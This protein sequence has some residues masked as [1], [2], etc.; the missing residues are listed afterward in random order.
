MSIQLREQVPLL[1]GPSTIPVA[2]WGAFAPRAI[3]NGTFL[4][5]YRGETISQAEANRRG[6]NLYDRRT[7]SYLFDLNDV[8]VD[9][10]RSPVITP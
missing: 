8:Q 3:E 7:S 1:I 10:P 6:L 4:V 9:L 2:G 5:E